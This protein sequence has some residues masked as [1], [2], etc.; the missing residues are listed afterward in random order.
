MLNPPEHRPYRQL[1]RP[2]FESKAIEPLEARVTDWTDRLLGEVAGAGECE[3]VSAVASRL[4]V[5]VFMELFGFPMERFDEFRHLVVEFFSARASPEERNALAQR[6]IGHLAELIQARM[7]EPR[8]DMISRIIA[9]EIDGRRL[10]FEEL[11]SIGFL[12]FLAGLDTVTN[13]MSFG[14]RHLAHDENLRR[15]AI[16]DPAVIPDLVEELLRRYAF[17][18]TPRYEN[19]RAHVC[20]PV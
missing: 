8:D 10:T 18:A 19:G 12:M 4:P 1:L 13:A 16:D 20:T 9:S 6:I 3:F 7:A 14:M 15:R 17:V 11:M 2:F 5:A